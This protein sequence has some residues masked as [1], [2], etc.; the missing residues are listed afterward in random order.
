MHFDA[1]MTRTCTTRRHG[2][3]GVSSNSALPRLRSLGSS[4]RAAGLSIYR[5]GETKSKI[6]SH[7]EERPL[8]RLSVDSGN[9]G[10][11]ERGGRVAGG[12]GESDRHVVSWKIVA[13]AE[14]ERRP[15]RAPKSVETGRLAEGGEAGEGRESRALKEARGEGRVGG[16]VVVS[17]RQSV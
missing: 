8:A 12:G 4:A 13:D 17:G 14:S 5:R 15:L 9:R 6:R 16:V 11:K 3:T 2:T 10:T 7:P 1:W